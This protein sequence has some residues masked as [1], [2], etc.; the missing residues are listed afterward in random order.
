MDQVSST[1]LEQSLSTFK[2]A[3]C[4]KESLGFGVGGGVVIA[5]LRY[6]QLRGQPLGAARAGFSGAVVFGLTCGVAWTVC[7]YRSGILASDRVMA[8]K[9]LKLKAMQD[10]NR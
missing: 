4:L 10:K 3:P 6:K 5:G 8:E 9:L 7:R 2:D 1:L